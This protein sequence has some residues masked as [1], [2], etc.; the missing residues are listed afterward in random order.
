MKKRIL[1][2]FY[3][4]IAFSLSSQEIE[5]KKLFVGTFTSEGA[6][7]I[8]LCLFNETSGNITLQKVFSG[9]D[10]PSFLQISPD[11]NFLYAV[12]RP[13][14]ES[15]RS[16]G[17]VHAYKIEPGGDLQF[18]NKQSSNGADP[19][20]IDISPD[21]N[22][23]AIATYGSGT[24]SLYKINKDGSL[25]IAGPTIKNEGSGP[26]PSR[27]K[28][29]HAHSVLFS[30]DGKQLFSADLG[31]DRLNIYDVKDGRLMPASQSH[32][33]I[34]PG[35]GPRHFSIHPDSKTIYVINELNSTITALR[36]TG[37]KWKMFQTIST[38]P[39]GFIGD[40]YCADI[41]VSA[42][43]RFLYGSNRGHNSI[44]VYSIDPK[45][46][47]LD[48]VTA[49]PTKGEWPRN[50]TLSR[51]GNFLL[52]AN[53][54]SGNITVFKINPENGIPE[55]TGKNIQLPSPVC[56]VFQ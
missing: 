21:G 20:H 2:L 56:L 16:N 14:G 31:T 24:V 18:L 8:Y 49:V 54:K 46:K 38:V 47:R 12:I 50:F 4:F 28:A 34:T 37:K 48:W 29:P 6:E 11:R 10:N 23:T 19:C 25:S 26:N 27:Q 52:A 5:E 17:Y 42:D 44:A 32:I 30:S 9:I 15:G 43:G 40:N 13:V 53:Q 39:D 51:N 1:F 55:F 7:G 45:S 22:F 35:A 41:H 33:K 36:K 3:A